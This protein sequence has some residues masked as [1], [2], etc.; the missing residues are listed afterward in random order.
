MSRLYVISGITGMTGSE[1]AR[2][3][4]AAGDC[5]IGF[6]NFFA[7][8]IGAIDDISHS[9][10]L[11]FFPFDLCNSAH[12]SA[13]TQV[14]GQ[15]FQSGQQLI[16]VNCA[17]VVHTEHFYKVEETFPVNV[18]GMRS[19]L[20]Q[21]I[22]L[23]ADVFI[24][25]STSEV[26]SMQSYKAGGVCES[27][28]LSLSTAEHSQRT[29]YATGKLMT[30]FFLRDAVDSG[31]IK[32]ASLRFAN[33]YSDWELH[34][35]HIIPH[36]VHSLSQTGGVT[37]LENAKDTHRTF[38]HNFDSCRSI[39]S[40]LDHPTALDGS[41][42][43]VAT[44]EEISILELAALIA[45]QLNLE[46]PKITFSG[47][48]ASDPPRRLLSSEKLTAATGWQPEIT[49]PHGLERV[50]VSYKRRKV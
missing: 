3:A 17:A 46:T 26:Y 30:E 35:K 38:L 2:Q 24:N 29:S 40:L 31:K 6:D 4:L 16:F 41:V 8:S 47:T 22:D 18:L 48:R 42:Y 36:L 37:L 45:A 1:L 5:V 50:I 25:C 23:A 27:D 7:S 13:I 32:G 14:I 20:S 11:T 10:R 44:S 21:A 34:P 39:L 19:F 15:Q 9:D 28:Y 12:M 33:V 49:L 43:N